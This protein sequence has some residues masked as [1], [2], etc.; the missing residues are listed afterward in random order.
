MA[1]I[2]KKEIKMN[3]T[4]PTLISPLLTGDEVAAALH[5]SRA[6]AYQLMRTGEI[7]SIK[8]GRS[9]RVRRE[10]LDAFIV[11]NINS[12]SPSPLTQ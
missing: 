9:I 4:Y 3:Q 2:E 5:V 1:G 12:K 10:D 8:I 6:Y 7:P 11:R